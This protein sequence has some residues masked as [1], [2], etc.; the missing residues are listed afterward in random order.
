MYLY[1]I[2]R[3]VFS[4]WRGLVVP[5]LLLGLW[6]WM[7]QQSAQ[8]A[9][10]FASIPQIHHGLSE[11]LASGELLTNLRAS[12][13]R[14]I[15]GLIIGASLGF[16]I[17]SL[18]AFSRFAD[19]LISPIYQLLR[20]VP[21]MGL[22]PLFALW[23]GNGDTS[24]LIMVAISSFY[25]VVL[26][27][28]EALHQVEHR[29]QA[30]GQVYKLNKWKIF[31]RIKLPAA[32]PQIFT[33]FSFALAF[34]WLSTIGSEILFTAGAGLGNMMMNAEQASRMDILIIIT[35]LIGMMGYSMNL[36]LQRIGARF[37]RWRNVRAI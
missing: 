27:T 21:L 16:L 12:I 15:T 4:G 5:L 34:A 10:T 32:L 29:Y 18:T 37:F 11:V 36:A 13:L 30:V 28:Y 24:K 17:G 1:N 2:T 14:A 20:Q 25:P 33:G 26:A 31:S 9:Y 8:N 23:Y 6:Q 3:K 7:A 35:I 19:Y 22:V